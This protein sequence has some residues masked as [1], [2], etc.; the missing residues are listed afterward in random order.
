MYVVN[1]HTRGFLAPYHPERS[2]GSLPLA[3]EAP[4]DGDPSLRSG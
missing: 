3:H 1:V 2:E 4:G